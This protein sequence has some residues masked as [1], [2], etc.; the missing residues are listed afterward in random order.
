M[1]ESLIEREEIVELLFNV[2]ESQNL[3][4]IVALLEEDDEE[5]EGD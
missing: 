3:A 4:W 5:E 2:S 1:P